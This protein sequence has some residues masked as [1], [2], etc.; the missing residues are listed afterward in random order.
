MLWDREKA[1]DGG[2]RGAVFEN[3]RFQFWEAVRHF[4]IN[5]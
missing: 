1:R 3:R 5:R 2:R 4:H